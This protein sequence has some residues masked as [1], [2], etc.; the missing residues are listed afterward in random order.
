MV[1][2]YRADSGVAEMNDCIP[3]ET[4]ERLHRGELPPAEAAVIGAHLRTCAPL[5]VDAGPADGTHGAP[6][7]ARGRVCEP[8]A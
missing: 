6:S 2:A 1:E 7:P 4:L 5:P 8:K 3:F